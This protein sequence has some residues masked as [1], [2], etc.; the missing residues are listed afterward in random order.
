MKCPKHALYLG[1]TLLC[2]GIA[3]MHFS[4]KTM[5]DQEEAPHI[6]SLQ[7]LARLQLKLQHIVPLEQLAQKKLRRAHLSMIQTQQLA[8]HPLHTST[9]QAFSMSLI[10]K[11]TSEKALK[12]FRARGTVDGKSL[13]EL[14]PKLYYSPTRGKHMRWDQVILKQ[15]LSRIATPFMKPEFKFEVHHLR[16]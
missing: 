11:L 7:E 9:G 12:E 4:L 3:S 13:D 6:R 15:A 10:K 5:E 16:I 1:C 2:I 14:I 8:S